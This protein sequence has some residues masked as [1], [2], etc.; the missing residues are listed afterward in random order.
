MRIVAE[1]RIAQSVQFQEVFVLWNIGAASLTFDGFSALPTSR[2]TITSGATGVE[3]THLDCCPAGGFGTGWSVGGPIG[4]P[5]V[6]FTWGAGAD[7][8][9]GALRIWDGIIPPYGKVPVAQF[10]EAGIAAGGDST[11][12]S[13][14]TDQSWLS[15]YLILA[16]ADEQHD[17]D[18]IVPLSPNPGVFGTIVSNAAADTVAQWDLANATAIGTPQVRGHNDGAGAMTWS[19]RAIGAAR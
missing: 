3:Q 2:L 13:I 16:I 7:T 18:A 15:R 17:L 4:G 14:P 5:V 19:M 8:Y 11:A 10:S 12:V 9:R 1:R 6:I